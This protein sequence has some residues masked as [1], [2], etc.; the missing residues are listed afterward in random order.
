MRS[1]HHDDDDELP[2]I[3]RRPP[4]ISTRVKLFIASERGSRKGLGCLLVL[5]VAAGGVYA[6]D[7]FLNPP[8]PLVCGHE[9]RES[10]LFGMVPVG[11]DCEGLRALRYLD[12]ARREIA[13]SD[14]TL[15]NFQAAPDLPGLG[16]APAGTPYAFSMLEGWRLAADPRDADSDLPH[17][18]LESDGTVR[19]QEGREA[20]LDSPRSGSFGR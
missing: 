16:R 13:A 3:K 9:G 4:R 10:Y 14:R 20:T 17:F 11:H 5:L 15:G 18:L 2:A 8:G 7:R 1:V 12:R 19:R 6:A